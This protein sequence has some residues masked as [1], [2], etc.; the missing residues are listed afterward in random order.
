M[1]IFID[2]FKLE[3]DCTIIKNQWDDGEI[4]YFGAEPLMAD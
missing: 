2:D 4:Q 3:D 1:K